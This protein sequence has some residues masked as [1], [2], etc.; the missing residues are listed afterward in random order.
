M[1]HAL[2]RVTSVEVQIGILGGK[3]IG[4][5][6]CFGYGR[7]YDVSFEERYQLIRNAGLIIE[8]IHAPVHEQNSLSSDNSEGDCGFEEV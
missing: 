3:M 6:D 8:N 1:P 2:W 4:I 7:G 5:Y